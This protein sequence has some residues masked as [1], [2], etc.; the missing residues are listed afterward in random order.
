[1]TSEFTTN[2]SRLFRINGK[3]ILIRGGG[4]SPD[5][6]LRPDSK[7]MADEFRMVLDMNLNTLRLEGK[8]E[9]EEFFRMATSKAS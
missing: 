9:S 5:M 2:G 3:P 7:R 4:W 8:L 6:L 1:M